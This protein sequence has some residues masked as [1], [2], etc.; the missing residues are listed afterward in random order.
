MQ[1]A[2]EY[3]S[4]ADA[5]SRRGLR[6]VLSAG[7]PGPWG[8]AAK[9]ILHV[10]S[11]PYAAVAQYATMANEEL[12]EWTGHANAPV[13]MCDDEPPRSGWAEILFLAE[14][15]AP[16]PSLVPADALERALMFGLAREICGEHGLGWSRRLMMIDSLVAPGA[17]EQGR[18]AGEVLGARY[19]YSAEVA[20]AAPA[21]VASILVA[22]SAQLG[23]QR[24]AGRD[25]LVGSSLTALDIYW[26]AFTVML[27]PLAGADCPLP[28]NL[29]R[30][31]SAVGPVVAAA[32]DPALLEHRDR[33]YRSY[34]KLP[35]TF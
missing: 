1:T 23:R 10:K 6:L 3:L 32:L 25:F 12:V 35:M 15:V 8:E 29:R 21:R 17:P 5:R 11:I 28:D 34:L 22:F 31:Y 9:S 18:R 20:A 16:E 26:A 13:A 14:R 30:W 7:V 19:G 4:V 24:A 2:F 33:I 27:A